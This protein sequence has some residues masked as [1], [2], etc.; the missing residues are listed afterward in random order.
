MRLLV[1]IDEAAERLKALEA[2]DSSNAFEMG[3]IVL[4]AVPM[5]E[6]E[7]DEDTEGQAFAGAASLFKDQGVTEALKELAEKAGMSWTTLKDR[8]TVASR[9]PVAARAATGAWRVFRVIAYI[10]PAQ[11]AEL[12]ALVQQPNPDREDG[13]WTEKAIRAHL[14]KGD[15]DSVGSKP[16]QSPEDIAIGHILTDIYYPLQ[17]KNDWR[18]L[19]AFR[20]E[21]P[22]FM[23]R[24]E[25]RLHKWLDRNIENIKPVLEAAERRDAERQI[26]LSERRARRANKQAS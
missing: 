4:A 3:D 15:G 16:Q 17:I 1:T 21:L 11:R 12:L 13:R 19:E 24:V 5:V 26:R 7:R 9:I 23:D 20:D 10:E 14:P 25:T 22:A 8:R 2:A 18:A 6:T